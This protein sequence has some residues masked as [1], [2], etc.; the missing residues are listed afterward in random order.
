MKEIWK[1]IEGYNGRYLISNL[2]RLKS[3]AQDRTNGKIKNGNMSFKGY[4]TVVLYDNDGNKKC[5]P[6]HRLVATAFLNNPDNL[7]QINHKDEVK[8]NNCVDNLEWCTN[9]YNCNYGTKIER[10]RKLNMCCKT[11]SLKVY[12]IDEN[13]NKEYFDSIG[14]AERR[15][16]NSHC[17]IVTALKGR[18]KT[19]GNRRWFY[20]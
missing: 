14:E 5:Y 1:E 3:Y 6:V 18:R 10:V 15:T 12:S 4:L 19:C 2:G 13:G 8:T 11:T 17:N 7:P 16:G 20:C 9:Y